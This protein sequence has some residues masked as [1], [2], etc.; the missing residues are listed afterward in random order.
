MS[1]VHPAMTMLGRVVSSVARTSGHSE[2]LVYV[3]ADH[4]S[5]TVR[6]GDRID[7]ETVGIFTDTLTASLRRLGLTN[8]SCEVSPKDGGWQVSITLH[9]EGPK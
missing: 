5:L 1:S 9:V 3:S 8:L 2:P 6:H 4:I 7:R